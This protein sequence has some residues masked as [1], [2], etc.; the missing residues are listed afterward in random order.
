MRGYPDSVSA[1]SR[2]DLSL[3]R[4]WC[5]SLILLAACGFATAADPADAR[6]RWLHGNIAEARSLYEALPDS[7]QK[8]I[9]LSRTWECDGE[10]D[11][12]AAVIDA[13]L[14]TSPADPDLLARRSEMHY[15]RGQLADALKTADAAIAKRDDQFLARWV[16]A[17]VYRDTGELEKSDAEFRWFVR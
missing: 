11:K 4:R 9:G 3:M 16:R 17:N 12:A 8:A 6:K 15:L 2:Q 1:T 13:A 5:A 14:K 10:Y 7:P